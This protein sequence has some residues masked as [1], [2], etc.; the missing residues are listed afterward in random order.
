MVTIDPKLQRFMAEA[1]KAGFSDAEIQ[2]ELKTRG[3]IP[4]TPATAE[5]PKQEGLIASLLH[6]FTRTAKNVG[7]AGFELLRALKAAGGDQNAYVNQ[8][9]GATVQN[10]F[11]SEKD[12]ETFADPKKAAE[13]AAKNTAGILAYAV[14]YGKGGSLLTRALVPGAVSGGASAYARDQNVVGGALTGAVTA[15]VLDKILRGADVSK[16]GEKLRQGVIK[17]KVAPTPFA[18]SE[19]EAI[20]KGTEQLGLKGSAAAQKA[21]IPKVM[22]DLSSQIKDKLAESAKSK[23]I[24]SD[25]VKNQVKASLEDNLNYVPGD[26]TFESAANRILG[27]LKGDTV[28]AS[29][30]F[31]LKQFLNNQLKNAFRKVSG[32]LQTPLTTQEQVGLAVWDK[33]DDIITTIEPGVKDLTLKQST[34][35]KAAPGIIKQAQAGIR[36]PFGG[37]ARISARPVQALQD[38]IGR[39]LESAGGKTVAVTAGVKAVENPLIQS[40]VGSVNPTA[41]NVSGGGKYKLEDILPQT[42]TGEEIVPEQKITTEQMQQVLLSPD[43]SKATK[44]RIQAA[45]KLQPGSA[46]SAA[47]RTQLQSVKSAVATLGTLAQNYTDVLNEGLTAQSPGLG[48]LAGVKGSVASILQSSPSAAAYEKT[49]EAFLSKLSRATGEKGVLTDQDI[50]RIKKA[51]PDFYDTPEVV[52]KSLANVQSIINGAVADKIGS[53]EPDLTGI[54]E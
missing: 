42:P 6:P 33:L 39:G 13:E 38:I 34:L 4:E 2:A 19:E 7:G 1:K 10:P 31:D 37:G 9:T 3:L 15:G 22:E 25:F 50:K 12:L 32:D 49:K 23:A 20:Q 27:R 40:I 44:D 8:E 41:P 48:R 52:A 30:V 28:T 46:L 29:D 36:I 26:P 43:I 47:E 5:A 54:T 45:Y 35:F 51:L 18:A 53:A 16:A 17:P 14:P 21:Q 24:S 11:L